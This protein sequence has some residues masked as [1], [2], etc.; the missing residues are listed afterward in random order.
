MDRDKIIPDPKLSIKKGGLAPLGVYKR[1]WIFDKIEKILQAQQFTL[2]TPIADID[3]ELIEL[4]LYGNEDMELGPLDS[5]ERF[6]GLLHFMGRHAEDSSTAIERWAQGFMHKKTCPSCSGYR[7]KKEALHF[8]IGDAHIGELAIMDLQALQDWCA[9]L[10]EM[11][12]EQALYIGK[13]IIK[14][15]IT[16][17]FT[18]WILTSGVI[19]LRWVC[20]CFDMYNCRNGSCGSGFK[21][22]R[23][24][25]TSATVKQTCIVYR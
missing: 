16:K 1:S 4:L 19:C 21:T 15:I 9:K 5:Q 8:K 10:P 20:F 3:D 11:L 6:E 23:A 13:E 22:Y 17:H 2:H 7:L 12:N 14:E 25:C 18:K 24:R